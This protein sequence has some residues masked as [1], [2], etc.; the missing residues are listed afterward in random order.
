MI[1]QRKPAWFWNHR[2][3]LKKK[4]C[5]TQRKCEIKFNIKEFLVHLKYQSRVQNQIKFPDMPA[6]F[7]SKYVYITSEGRVQ[8]MPF[9][10]VLKIHCLMKN[11]EF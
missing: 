8:A 3:K 9:D 4:S 2:L 11:T 5:G 7:L 1:N 6:F 10:Q